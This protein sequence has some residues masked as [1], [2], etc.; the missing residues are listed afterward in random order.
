MLISQALAQEV[1]AAVTQPGMADAFWTNMGLIAIM[2]LL[3][4]FLLIRP[5]QKRLQKQRAMLDEL[6]KGDKVVTGGGLYG[7]VSKI[8][9]DTEVEVDLGQTKVT[10]LRYTIQNRVEDDKDVP[11]PKAAEKKSTAKKTT[12]K[13]AA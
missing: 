3:F 5:Q 11:L 7:S 1:G 13:K 2:F 9:S 8:I 4:Y 6:K 10:A 12:K